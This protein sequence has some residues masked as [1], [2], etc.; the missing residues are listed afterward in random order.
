M[1]VPPRCVES[2]DMM[3]PL[4]A[5]ASYAVFR[6][7]APGLAG[8]CGLRR[9]DRTGA[10]LGSGAAGPLGDLSFGSVDGR[11]REAGPNFGD[12]LGG[13]RRGVVVPCLADIGGDG[14][15]V[16]IAV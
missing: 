9:G 4:P 15:D 11:W 5:G 7:A 13:D 6:C 2:R 10:N 14:G 8:R 3:M 16:L 12:L 1:G